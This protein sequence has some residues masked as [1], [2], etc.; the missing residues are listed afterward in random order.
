MSEGLKHNWR[1]EKILTIDEAKK[2]ALELKEQGKKLVTTNGVFDIM[3]AGHLD[4]LEEYKKQGD[5]LFIGLNSDK[6]VKEGKGEDRPYIPEMERA[7]ML[8]A[9]ACVDYVVIIDALYTEVQDVLLRT[10]RPDIHGNLDEY[11]EPD[12]WIEWPV[13]Q[14]VGAEGYT[15]KRRAGLSTSDIIQKIKS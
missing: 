10:V 14:E 4:A 15:C 7:A 8:A 6:S 3:H 11:G 9:L 13:M 5:V 12:N 2:K 1:F